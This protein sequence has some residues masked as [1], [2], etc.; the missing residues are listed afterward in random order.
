MKTKAQEKRVMAEEI[1]KRLGKVYMPTSG[2]SRQT[3][4]ALVHK[5]TK[6]E[7][8]GLYFMVTTTVE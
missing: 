6:S 2:L 5:L 3:V 8:S 4:N 1:A 7:L